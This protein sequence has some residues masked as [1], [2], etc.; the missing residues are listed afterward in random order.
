MTTMDERLR[1]P[2]NARRTGARSKLFD[3][4]VDFQSG[5]AK[6]RIWV[7]LGWNDIQRSY[8]RSILGPFWLTASMGIMVLLPGV[9]YA[10]LFQS[11]LSSFLPFLCV[12]LLLWNL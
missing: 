10:R 1:G 9:L 6:W 8:R 2:V 4:F 3:A 12:G 7:R 5:L 11:Q